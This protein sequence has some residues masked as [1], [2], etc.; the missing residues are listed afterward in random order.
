MTEKPLWW[1]E[2][3]VYQIYPRSFKD[4]N[5][6]GTGDVR[7]IIQKL[8]YLAWLGVGAIWLSPM[9]VSPMHDF[10]YDIQN[11]REIDPVYGS[12]EDVKELITLA[13]KKKI[14]I[15]FDMVLNHTSIEHVWFKESASSVDSPKRDFYIWS[16]GRGKRPP[17]NWYAAFGGKAWTFDK[18]TGYW[19]LHSFLP[20]QPDLNW[21]NPKMVKAL[22]EEMSF[23]F[24]L[25]VDGFR[26]DVINLIV[27][28]ELLRDNP[29]G[30]GGRPRPYDL[31]RHIYDRDRPEAHQVL[32]QFRSWVDTYPERML[33]GEIMVE[34]GGDPKLAASYM[35]NGED[36]LHLAFDFSFTNLPWKARMWRS[37]AEQWYAAVPSQGWPTWVLGNHDVERFF[38]KYG[39]NLG[40]LYVAALFLLTQK[41]TPFIYYGEELALPERPVKR[42]ELQDPVGKRYWPLHK[43]RDGARRPMVWN[44]TKGRGF[45]TGAA[46][47]PVYD[48][49]VV[50][51]E[52]QLGDP[53]SPLH[54]YRDMIW[55]RNHDHVLKWGDIKW[56]D[57]D[58]SDDI[59]AY[60][61]D[62][63]YDKRLVLLN[64]SD[65][66]IDFAAYPVQ[67]VMETNS[68]RVIYSTIPGDTSVDEAP[69]TFS[70]QPHQGLVCTSG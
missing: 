30:W 62:D 57:I 32:K 48:T 15:I 64:F 35:G 42:N 29:L 60:I 39:E 51:Y 26:L 34:N 66:G 3:V 69:D 9:Y 37:A 21:R 4:S 19:Y 65:K 12:L 6:D 50:S 40:R 45:T 7:G 70:L 56:L 14:R 49:Q 36:E 41:G 55:I 54:H 28:D 67:K 13:H 16:K 18:H 61:R 63:G 68:L 38:S 44:D 2:V 23:W 47:L 59:L 46:W 43:G 33:V 22:F 10:G 20:E 11:Y 8:E 24:D 1:K 53:N 52:S 27:K 58:D 5:G 17:N 25:G 31:Q